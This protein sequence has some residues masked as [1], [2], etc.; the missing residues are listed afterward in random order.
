MEHDRKRLEGSVGDW[1]V[2]KALLGD[3]KVELATGGF[4]GCD[5]WC[6]RDSIDCRINVLKSNRRTSDWGCQVAD[7]RSAFLTTKEAAE[8]MRVSER[9]VER[10]AREGRLRWYKLGDR[11]GRRF[12]R[13]DLDGGLVRGGGGVGMWAWHGVKPLTIEE[14]RFLGELWGNL[15]VGPEGNLTPSPFPG[16]EGGPE[17]RGIGESLKSLPSQGR[18]LGRGS[19]PARGVVRGQVVEDGKQAR[20]KELRREMTPEER[21]L[22]EALRGNRLGGLHFRRQ[23]VMRGFIADF[24]CD[25]AAL[26]VEVDGGSHVGREAY[27]RER[28]GIF[29]GLGIEVLRIPAELVTQD[30]E[31]VLREIGERA[32][33]T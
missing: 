19:H 30:L 9:T 13:E 18:D 6:L 28:D 12:R 10:F 14:S 15:R 5:I 26:V 11:R 33:G 2:D 16:K 7:V 8:Y 22:W 4:V 25:A 21:V 29:R 3:W 24:Y 1:T 27:D 17:G 20:A 32:R 23:Q 31:G